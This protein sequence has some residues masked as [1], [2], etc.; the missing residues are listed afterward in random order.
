MTVVFG[1]LLYLCDILAS[2]AE[3]DT[4]DQSKQ[5]SELWFGK[6][7]FQCQNELDDRHVEGYHK[8]GTSPLYGKLLAW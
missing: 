8:N 2:G 4:M 1:S 5:M 7:Q 6:F 3:N